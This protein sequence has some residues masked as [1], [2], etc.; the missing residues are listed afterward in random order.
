MTNQLHGPLFSRFTATFG[1][2][3]V[4][5]RPVEKYDTNPEGGAGNY[6][7]AED[8]QV[9]AYFNVQCDI[10]DDVLNLK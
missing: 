1:T 4:L 10:P 6:T 3:Y 2:F 9:Q 5:R 8:T 7:Q